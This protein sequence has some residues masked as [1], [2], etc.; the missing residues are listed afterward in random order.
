MGRLHIIARQCSYLLQMYYKCGK[1]RDRKHGITIVFAYCLLLIRSK[2]FQETAV[3]Q[4]CKK[5]LPSKSLFLKK[6]KFAETELHYRCFP[7]FQDNYS[8]EHQ[9]TVASSFL[10]CQYALWYCVGYQW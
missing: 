9:L 4:K 2:Y 6:M 8:T 7:Y 5:N 1:I 3:L 10:I